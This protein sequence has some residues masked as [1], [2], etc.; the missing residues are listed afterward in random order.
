[1]QNPPDQDPP[2]IAPAEPTSPITPLR[3]ST[4]IRKPPTRYNSPQPSP[5][6]RAKPRQSSTPLKPPATA[7]P[8][9]STNAPA[10]ATKSPKVPKKTKAVG[11]AEGASDQ[12]TDP[13]PGPVVPKKKKAGRKAKGPLSQQAQSEPSPEVPKTNAGGR[14][15]KG[16][17]G[18]KA[19]PKPTP[20]TEFNAVLGPVK[21]EATK[22]ETNVIDPAIKSSSSG[23]SDIGSVE[24]SAVSGVLD[25]NVDSADKLLENWHNPASAK[26]QER[27][28]A[29]I[30]SPTS[31]NHE[32]K[33]NPSVE[34]G[35]SHKDPETESEMDSVEP[36]IAK[37]L[38]QIGDSSD[39]LSQDHC[40][41]PKPQ[42]HIDVD[43]AQSAVG[44]TGS[45]DKSKPGPSNSASK[46]KVLLFEEHLK[47]ASSNLEVP[48]GHLAITG[49]T[50]NPH[51]HTEPQENPEVQFGSPKVPMP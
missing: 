18:Q 49:S 9:S 46:E 4:R 31:S 32:E 42:Q 43:G 25:Q 39:E 28:D 7:K 30:V 21:A 6:T 11:K 10:L 27:V 12:K 22:T 33:L 41:P 40:Y 1:M 29:A 5:A 50:V 17:A 38:D 44:P 26:P 14:K 15:G 16:L 36:E 34:K 2:A 3:R 19:N 37:L 48:L 35:S 47:P 20:P 51:E 8:G 23:K 45:N 13:G 24:P